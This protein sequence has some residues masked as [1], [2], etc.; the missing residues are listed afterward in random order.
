MTFNPQEEFDDD[1]D[2]PVAPPNVVR[3]PTVPPHPSDAPTTVFE[4]QSAEPLRIPTR[5]PTHEH[6][7]DEA[8]G[9][10]SAAPSGEP[11]VMFDAPTAQQNQGFTLPE[12]GE[13]KPAASAPAEV[14]PP[15]VPAPTEVPPHDAA[16]DAQLA[17]ARR[18]TIDL[19][20]F[21]IRV[22]FGAFLV[23]SAVKTFF[24][25]GGDTG[26]AGLEA[27]YANYLQPGILAVAIPALLLTAGVFLVLGLV[28]PVAAALATIG[29]AFEA[30]HLLDTDG[31]AFDVLRLSDSVLLGL[32]L[33]ALSLGLQ[34][35]GPGRLAVDYGR[36][37]SRRPLVSS[38]LFAVIG[39]AGAAALWWFGAGV[40][41]FN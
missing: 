12:P 36:S 38:W 37:W 40:N 6:E 19:G 30:L 32:L 29:T 27:E 31:E 35:T 2:I 8:K 3:K 33:V 18:G 26:L 21:I 14:S 9:E 23:F 11:T 4:P 24:Q 22:V 25:L 17:D 16:P 39:V 10:V 15:V 13:P 34:F 5:N 20:V 1:V 28:T 41:P 7:G